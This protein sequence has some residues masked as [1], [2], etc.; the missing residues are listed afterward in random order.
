MNCGLATSSTVS[1]VRIRQVP[2]VNPGISQAPQFV[3]PPLPELRSV[4]VFGRRISYYDVGSGPTLVLVHGLGGDADEWVWCFGPLS[5]THRVIALEMLGFGRS[6]KPP[7]TYRIA[8]FVEVLER[9]LLTLEIERASLLGHS[10]GGW[11][12]AA[13]AL[14][15]PDRVDKLVLADAAGID[16]GAVKPAIDLNVSTRANMRT[17]LEFVFYSKPMVTDD[18]VELSYTLHLERGDG[19]TIRSALETV[20]A[21]DEKLDNRLSGLQTPTLLLW[22]EQDALTPLAMA[23]NFQRL[24]HGSRLE[25]I[26]ECGHIPCLEKPGE[27]VHAVMNFLR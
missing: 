22:G 21:P 11:I 27:F 20:M 7:I 26:P 15:F 12:V 24:I 1:A 6:D 9:F 23:E 10:L 19:P 25:V 14:Q 13:F 8:G 16:A 18:L 17:I 5:A 4:S 2:I 3:L